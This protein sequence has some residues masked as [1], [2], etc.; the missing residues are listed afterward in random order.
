VSYTVDVHDDDDD[1]DDDGGGGDI[2][3]YVSIF[4][5]T[6]SSLYCTLCPGKTI[7]HH[8]NHHIFIITCH[9]LG[10]NVPVSASS[11]ILFKG[12]PNRLCPVGL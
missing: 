7:S 3:I 5:T 11:N 2:C 9:D 6:V 12:F 4:L 8:H 10:L 1:D